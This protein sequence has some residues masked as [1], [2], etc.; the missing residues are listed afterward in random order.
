MTSWLI[1]L[2]ILQRSELTLQRL[3]GLSLNLKRSYERRIFGV[4]M[5]QDFLIIR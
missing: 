2:L 1:K 4:V 3:H 5:L